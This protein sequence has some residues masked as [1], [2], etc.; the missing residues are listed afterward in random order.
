M[1]PL[2][3]YRPDDINF[4]TL[5]CKTRIPVSPEGSIGAMIFPALADRNYG[6]EH[7]LQI[8]VHIRTPDGP[9]ENGLSTLFA[10]HLGLRACI[11]ESEER[12]WSARKAKDDLEDFV[13]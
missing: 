3:A 11:Q 10:E 4:G 12:R 5:I 8:H 7:F 9:S 13:R 1:N 2:R 6:A